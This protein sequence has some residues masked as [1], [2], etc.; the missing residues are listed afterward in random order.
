MSGWNFKLVFKFENLTNAICV[1]SVFVII[2]ED[3]SVK[4]SIKKLISS[5]MDFHTS[6]TF[7]LTVNSSFLC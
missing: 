4:I 1:K 7:F 5:V 2:M 3:Y 6:I